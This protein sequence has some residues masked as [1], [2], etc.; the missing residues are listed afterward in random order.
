MGQE[1]KKTD[2]DDKTEPKEK[3]KPKAIVVKEEIK[4]SVELVDLKEPSLKKQEASK[5]M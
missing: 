3:K 2:K 1:D 5:K 4:T